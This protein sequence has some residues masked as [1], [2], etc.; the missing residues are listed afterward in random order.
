MLYSRWNKRA[1][2]SKKF[3]EGISMRSVEFGTAACVAFFATIFICGVV[4]SIIVVQFCEPEDGER[5]VFVKRL[6]AALGGFFWGAI[7]GWAAGCSVA[8]F[9]VGRIG[10]GIVFAIL[11]AFL[12]T[13]WYSLLPTQSK[14][15]L[16]RMVSPR[17]TLRQD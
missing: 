11:T 2:C 14:H 15:F 17:R 13:I 6:G 8:L 5:Y 10:G 16:A 12:G 7:P 3:K 1:L 4:G 9:V